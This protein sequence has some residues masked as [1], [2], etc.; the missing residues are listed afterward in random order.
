MKAKLEMSSIPGHL[1][2]FSLLN[3]FRVEDKVST[4]T[5]SS[6]GSKLRRCC[7]I[8]SA[9]FRILGLVLSDWA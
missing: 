2:F 1:Q 8:I 4:I 5:A 3:L 6:E 7:S 9:N